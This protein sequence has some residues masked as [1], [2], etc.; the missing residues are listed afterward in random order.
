MKPREPTTFNGSQDLEV[1]TRFLD[2]VE[3]YVHQGASMCPT[4]TLNNQHIDTIWRFLSVKIFQWFELEMLKSGVSKIPPMNQVYG[5]TWLSVKTAFK[6]QF[7]PVVAV[8]VVHKEW[9]G[10]KFNKNQ[11]LKFNHRALELVEILGG[12]LKITCNKPLWEEYLL[13]LPEVLS[14]NITQQA[15]M[16]HRI[17]KTDLTFGDMMEVVSERTL[18]YLPAG[19]TGSGTTGMNAEDSSQMLQHFRSASLTPPQDPMDFSNVEDNKVNEINE[20]MKCYQ[21]LG[22]GHLAC[23]YATPSNSDRSARFR[24]RLEPKM[25]ENWRRDSTNLTD[26]KNLP[27]RQYNMGTYK[28]TKKIHQ[29]HHTE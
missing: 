21:C 26:S 4:A 6:E 23:Q 25:R 22:F 12:S 5:I 8:L 20:R 7:V 27:F 16:T 29:S 1:V 24:S 19:K 10:L 18:P 15:Q 17:N 14:H 2:E 9:H 3:H 28:L 13:K 11:V